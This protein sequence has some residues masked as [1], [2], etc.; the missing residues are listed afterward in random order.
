MNMNDEGM[1][2]MARGSGQAAGEEEGRHV[3]YTTR[4]NTR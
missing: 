2:R 3:K 1:D 4:R